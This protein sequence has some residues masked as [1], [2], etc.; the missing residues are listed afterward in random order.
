[1]RPTRSAIANPVRSNH[2]VFQQEH[3]QRLL[4]TDRGR[5]ALMHD[6]ELVDIFEDGALAAAEGH[7]RFGADG[8]SLHLIGSRTY[9]IAPIIGTTPLSR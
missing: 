4:K 6:G 9:Y 2:A 1:M 5:V 3:E 7:R 8:F